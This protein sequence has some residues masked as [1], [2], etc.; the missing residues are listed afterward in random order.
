MTHSYVNSRSW[1]SF[2]RQI[3]SLVYSGVVSALDT[4]MSF[5]SHVIKDRVYRGSAFY[6][7]TWA[8]LM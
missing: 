8:L 7:N 3:V 6:L 2:G 1:V 4:L 5:R